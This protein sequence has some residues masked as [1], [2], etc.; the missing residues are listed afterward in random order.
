MRE[1]VEPKTTVA[2]LRNLRHNALVSQLA[3]TR[4]AFDGR[5][6]SVPFS[7][8]AK[9][10]RSEEVSSMRSTRIGLWEKRI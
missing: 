3:G 7:H 4:I 2:L 6:Q 8:I 5:Q 10:E 1:I 9:V